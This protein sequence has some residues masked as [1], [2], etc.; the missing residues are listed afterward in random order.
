[1]VKEAL[2]KDALGFMLENHLPTLRSGYKRIR[3]LQSTSPNKEQVG[4]IL[5]AIENSISA[6][7]FKLE[8]DR[9]NY[10]SDRL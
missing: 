6:I 4:Q 10:G 1:M 8:Q 9:L 5:S 2:N 7:E 3:E